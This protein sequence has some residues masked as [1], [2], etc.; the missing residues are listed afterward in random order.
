MAKGPKHG[1]PAARNR[2]PASGSAEKP[3]AARV[4]TPH[5]LAPQRGWFVILAA[6]LAIWLAFLL[7][8]RMTK[9]HPEPIIPATSQSIN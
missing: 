2:T 6:L 3:S 5:P 4:F 7:V 1:R 8:L 9:V